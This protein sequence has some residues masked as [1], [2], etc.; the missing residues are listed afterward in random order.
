MH[1]VLPGSK[2]R[3]S[4]RRLQS[5]LPVVPRRRIRLHL[6]MAEPVVRACNRRLMDHALMQRTRTG[7]D[8]T[9]ANTLRDTLV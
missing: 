4:V 3:C 5:A 8:Q 6:L 1:L 2:W 7:P 9:A